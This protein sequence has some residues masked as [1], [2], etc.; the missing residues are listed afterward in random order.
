MSLTFASDELKNDKDIVMEAVKSG[1]NGLKYASEKLKNDINVV[2]AA[3]KNHPFSLEHASE[4]MKSNYEVLEYAIENINTEITKID[5]IMSY[6]SRE[7]Q[8]NNELIL[9]SLL[10]IRNG[11]L[12]WEFSDNIYL[13]NNDDYN[14]KVRYFQ[15]FTNRFGFN[16]FSFHQFDIHFYF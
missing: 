3:I 11:Y 8:N 12:D 4:E 7:L 1:G 13:K 10:K 2:F 6:A 14:L 16:F 9:K 5:N 15:C